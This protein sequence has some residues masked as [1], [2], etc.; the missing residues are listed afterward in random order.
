MA[1]KEKR[2]I[3]VIDNLFSDLLGS[4]LIL[5]TYT[6]GV[7][8]CAAG[9]RYGDTADDHT[10]NRFWG[11]TLMSS[12]NEPGIPSTMEEAD[13]RIRKIWE[14]LADRFQPYSFFVRE[15]F[16]N[17]Q[18]YGLDNAIHTDRQ[19][20][21]EG[22]YTVLVYLNPKWTIHDGGETLFYNEQRNDII[23]SVIPKPG[24]VVF[25]DSRYPHWGRGPTR[26]CQELRVTLAYRLTRLDDSPLP[27]F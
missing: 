1:T 22:W 8:S 26:N 15:V 19:T 14:K 5:M 20:D 12:E 7:R 2:V 3:A 6:W 21:E 16:L 17:G 18:T 23:L 4:D 10:S 25:F 11:A 24:R 13:D 27:V 9:W